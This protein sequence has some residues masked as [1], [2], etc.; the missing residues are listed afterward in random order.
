MIAAAIFL[1]AVASITDGDTLRCADGT[2][3]RLAAIDTAEMP[4]ACQPGRQCVP[5]DPHA[6]RR[7]L[8]SLAAGRTLRCERTGTSYNRVA[9]FCSARGVDLS[10]A[11]LRSGHAFYVARYDRGGRLRRCR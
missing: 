7:Q 10:C 9:A 1:C 11:M 4:G 2:R 6:A 8:Q 3:I 5:G